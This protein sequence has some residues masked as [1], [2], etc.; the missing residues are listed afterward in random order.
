MPVS[1]LLG[2]R[3]D[4]GKAD[5]GIER[6]AKLV[7][8]RGE[9][10]ALQAVHLK[11]GHIGLGQ[12]VDLAVEVAIDLTQLLLHRDQI[13]QHAVEGMRKLLE[14]VARFGSCWGCPA[15]RRRSRRRRRVSA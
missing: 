9:E 3:E 2:A 5:D 11:Q 10:I 12:L 14:F 1:Q 6:R 13:V 4:L 8:H 7:A 15:G